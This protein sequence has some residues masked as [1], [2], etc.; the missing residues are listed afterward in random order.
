MGP[1][2]CGGE[3]PGQE[4][5]PGLCRERASPWSPQCLSELYLGLWEGPSY[6]ITASNCHLEN[7]DLR[8]Q[9]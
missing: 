2:V 9:L 7:C 3:G 8:V 4:H 6:K 5:S 1:G